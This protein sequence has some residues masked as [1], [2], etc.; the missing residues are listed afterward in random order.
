MRSFLSLLIVATCLARVSFGADSPP[1][2]GWIKTDFGGFFMYL[3]PEFT[4]QHAQGIDSDVRRYASPTIRIDS[5]YGRY[6]GGGHPGHWE[7]IPEFT[8]KTVSIDGREGE[9]VSMNEARLR[10]LSFNLGFK[11]IMSIAFARHPDDKS[12]KSLGL[13][14]MAACQSKDDYATLERIFSTIKFK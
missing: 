4:D 6:S 5:D 14:I 1:P 12:R 3:P 11:N 9:I 8:R 10:D 7:S 2:D 13:T